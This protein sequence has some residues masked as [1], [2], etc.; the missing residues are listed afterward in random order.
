MPKVTTEEHNDNGTRHINYCRGGN[1]VIGIEIS[2]GGIMTVGR[3]LDDGRWIRL[4][5]DIPEETPDAR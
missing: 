3:W 5:T 2:P 4:H 1:P